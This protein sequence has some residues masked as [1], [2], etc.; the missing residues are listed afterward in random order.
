MQEFHISEIRWTD[1]VHL[2]RHHITAE[3]VIRAVDMVPPSDGPSAL[4]CGGYIRSRGQV[5]MDRDVIAPPINILVDVDDEG[6]VF[7]Q[8]TN[9]DIPNRPA[10]DL[11]Y[12]F[13]PG[14]DDYHLV[15]VN[16]EGQFESIAGAMP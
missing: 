5:W 4:F 7:L 12:E 3:N 11:S 10:N 6:T 13:D 8:L 9:A 2:T 14:I 1:G 16:T 15:S